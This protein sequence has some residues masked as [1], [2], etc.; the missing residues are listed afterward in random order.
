MVDPKP[1]LNINKGN[2]NYFFFI[3][4]RSAH[5][6]LWE[7]VSVFTRDMSARARYDFSDTT[8]FMVP[9]DMQ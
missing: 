4:P 6:V 7:V 9:P 1:A 8:T 5:G 2:G 3:H